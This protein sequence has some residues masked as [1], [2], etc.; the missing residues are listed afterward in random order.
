MTGYGAIPGSWWSALV[1]RCRIR[2]LELGVTIEDMDGLFTSQLHKCAFTGVELTFDPS[3]ASLDRVDSSKGYV[4][5]NVQWVH[6]TINIMKS[7]MSS[8]ELVEWCRRV[9]AYHE[10]RSSQP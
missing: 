1:S 3:T 4:P 7:T 6:K 8:A 9:V 5:G 10:N 2:H